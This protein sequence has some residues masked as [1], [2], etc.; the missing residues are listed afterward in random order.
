MAEKEK[1]TCKC[2]YTWWSRVRFDTTRLCKKCYKKEYVNRNGDATFVYWRNW[3]K[4]RYGLS[5]QDYENLLDSQDCCCAICKKDPT[6][7]RLHIDHDHKTGRI[8]G[9]LCGNCNR[10]IGYMKDSIQNLKSAA[11]YLSKD[12]TKFV[13][14]K[15]GK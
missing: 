10:G 14:P 12:A 8:R 5:V 1:L 11:E 4:Y 2:G 3:L 9:L 6:D 13:V 7:E 15:G